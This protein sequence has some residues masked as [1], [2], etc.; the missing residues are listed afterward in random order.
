MNFTLVSIHLLFLDPCAEDGRG[1][2]FY[3]FRPQ[4]SAIL[5]PEVI[6]PFIVILRIR[7]DAKVRPV[8]LSIL[9]RFQAICTLCCL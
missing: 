7:S 1:F 2:V 9:R 5:D 4:F 8:T 6:H 3:L